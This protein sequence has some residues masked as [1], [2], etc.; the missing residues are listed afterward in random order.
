[1]SRNFD[2]RTIVITGGA[3]GIG[4]ALARSFARVGAK[5]ALLDLPQ[6][7]LAATRDK[8]AAHGGE[9]IAVPCDVT[10]NCT[11]AAQSSLLQSKGL[12]IVMSS[13]AGLRSGGGARWLRGL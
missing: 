7:P 1:M 10:E 3:G 12:I 13:I 8:I 6:S 4:T 5:I 11:K 9:V 2:G